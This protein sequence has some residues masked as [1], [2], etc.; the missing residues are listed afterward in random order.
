MALSVIILAA[1]KGTRMK[2]DLPKVLHPLA[3]KPIVEHI[4]DA[5]KPLD[6]RAINLVYGHGGEMLKDRLSHH[7]LN[8]CLQAEQLGTGHAV[9]QAQAHVSDDDDALILVGDA[10]LISTQTLQALVLAKQQH[11]LAL[12]TV[13]MKDPSGMG[14]IIRDPQQQGNITAIV[15]HKDA[16]EAQLKITEINTGMMIMSGKD[17]K[18]WLAAL[19]NDNAQGEYY[20]TDVIAMAA[21][22]GKKIGAAQP[23]WQKEVEGIN[24]RAQLASLE[25]AYQRKQAEDLLLAGVHIFDPE[26]IDIR[27]NI[28]VGKD[29]SIDV[30]AVFEGEVS[31]GDRV[32]IGPSCVLK[33]CVIG[34]DTKVEAFSHIEDAS[35]ESNCQIG[36]YARL[37]PKAELAEGVKIGN[38]VEVKKAKIGKGSKVNHLSYVGDA[39]VGTNVN[40]G[41]GT[42]TCNYDGVN[43]F[44]TTIADGVFV[45]SNSAL[46]AP[47]TI[48][49][50]ATVGAGSTVTK[51]IA[52]KELAVARSKQR[53]IQDWVR[54]SKLEK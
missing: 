22:E 40:I 21:N 18:R 29:V 12:L 32:S 10:P 13:N 3:N 52:D 36:P 49:A 7:E 30:N 51:D 24:N 54:P 48:G 14:R 20:L 9:M 26:R 45:G 16:T 5:V 6:Y 2:S 39:E 28:Q 34:A 17:L 47:V 8:W 25:R 31:L 35:L 23:A 33:N 46:V 19:S 27:G 53:N 15:E 42:I 43:K 41:A 4:I 37:R 44:K 11:D 1:G 38:F 50:H